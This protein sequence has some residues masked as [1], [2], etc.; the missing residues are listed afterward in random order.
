MV[1][2]KVSYKQDKELN[3]LVAVL[4]KTAYSLTIK[5]S[6]NQTGQYKKAYIEIK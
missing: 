4:Q 1:K 6:K 3:S 5:K 2:L